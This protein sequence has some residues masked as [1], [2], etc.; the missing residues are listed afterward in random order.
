MGVR[1]TRGK[2]RKR[3]KPGEEQIVRVKVPRKP[4]VF[5]LIEQRLGGNKMR[6]RCSD[7][8]LR[9]GRVPGKYS[10]RLWLREGNLVIVKPWEVQG[11][12]RGDIIYSYSQAQRDWL[13]RNNL[14]PEEFM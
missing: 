14:L 2:K 5:G 4:E 12:E 9:I 10:R 7:G 13:I 1:R 11:H 6:V 3:P 8:K